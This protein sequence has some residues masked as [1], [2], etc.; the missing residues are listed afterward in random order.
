MPYYLIKIFDLVI[1]LLLVTIPHYIFDGQ[2]FIGGDDGRLVYLYPE[3]WRLNIGLY[4]WANISGTGLHN[5]QQ[6]TIPISY[7]AQITQK[8]LGILYGTYFMYSLPLIVAYIFF[9]KLVKIFNRNKSKYEYVVNRI[10]ATIYIFSPIIWIESMSPFIGSIWVVPLSPIILYYLIRYI[11]EKELLILLKIFA[12]SILLSI[13][14]YSIPWIL[15]VYLPLAI[16]MILVLIIKQKLLTKDQFKS[17]L[18]YFITILFSQLFWLFPFIATILDKT[19]SFTG[20]VLSNDTVDT[21]SP[22]IEANTQNISLLYPI[23]NLFFKSIAVNSNWNIE[24]LNLSFYDYLLMINIFLFLVLMYSALKN[25]NS[26]ELEEKLLLLIW[27]I[28]LAFFTVKIG[29]FYNIIKLIFSINIMNMFRNFY[30]KFSIGYVFWFSLLINILLLRVDKLRKY[31]FICGLIAALIPIT[32]VKNEIADSLWGAKKIKLFSSF[33]EEYLDLINKIDELQ[34]NGNVFT[35]P[36]A[37]P[38]YSVLMNENRN[39]YYI[40]ITPLEMMTGITE[41]SGFFSFNLNNQRLLSNILLLSN[42]NELQ[43]LFN[44][45]N[46]KYI[47]LNKKTSL[48]VSNSYIYQGY[49]NQDIINENLKSIITRLSL[50]KIYISQKESFEIYL[51]KNINSNISKI[52]PVEYKNLNSNNRFYETYNEGWEAY[53]LS[54]IKNKSVA[55]NIIYKNLEKIDFLNIY[56]LKYIFLDKLNKYSV[57]NKYGKYLA[58]NREV[59]PK[60]YNYFFRPQLFFYYGILLSLSYFIFLIILYLFKRCTKN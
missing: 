38:A 19:G 33:T 49:D 34:I 24:L 1:I 15:G 47:L 28:S 17:I 52:S 57:D 50:D 30:D 7:I 10:S 20:L 26:L 2:Y 51:N 9:V 12:I 8:V 54:S 31:L 56:L 16:V 14:Y 44:R 59:G 43:E 13:G 3:K 35:I 41:Y 42:E 11:K 4:S 39:S 53:D 6:F 22:I 32:L 21:V 48:E 58:V 5:P 37:Y 25:R 27:I 29:Y 18:I 46:I 60:E 55:E 45:F 40:G 23:G 36:L